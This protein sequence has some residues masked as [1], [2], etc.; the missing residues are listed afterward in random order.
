[1]WDSTGPDPTRQGRIDHTQQGPAA[2]GKVMSTRFNGGR[3]QV[4][5]STT[6]LED[7][8]TEYPV[9]IDPPWS[10]GKLAWTYVDQ[11]YPTT[12]YYNSTADAR[13]GYEA[14]DGTTKRSFFRIDISRVRGTSITAATFALTETWSWSCS[15]RAMQVWATNSISSSTTWNSQPSWAYKTAEKSFAY[16]WYP[17]GQSSPCPNPASGVEFDVKKQVANIAGANGSNVT[18]GLRATNESDTYSW[19]KFK[20]NPT[21]SIQYDTLPSVPS[22]AT[23]IPSTPCSGGYIGNTDVSLSAIP[24]D[25]DGGQVKAQFKFWKST[26]TEPT[27][28]THTVLGTSGTSAKLQLGRPGEGT[29]KWRVRTGSASTSSGD[30]A[31]AYTP[32]C[33]FT[34]DNTAPVADLVTVSSTQFPNYDTTGQAGAPAGVPASFSIRPNDP[35]VTT[36]KVS[37]GATTP[38]V[39]PV[40]SG[41]ATVTLL[42]TLKGP[43]TLNVTVIDGAGN[44]GGTNSDFELFATLPPSRTLAPHDVT[45]DG[46]PDVVRLMTDGRLCLYLGNGAGGFAGGSG[47]TF[48]TPSTFVGTERPVLVGDWND[49][50]TNDVIVLRAN[51]LC[52]YVGNGTGSF[53]NSC[54]D[55]VLDDVTDEI[56]DI[57]ATVPYTDI[58]PAGDFDGDGDPD[59]FG[60]DSAGDLWLVSNERGRILTR[61]GADHTFGSRIG[62]GWGPLL[63]AVPGDVNGDGKPDTFG[64]VTTNGSLNL[65]PGRD[66]TNCVAYP[67]TGQCGFGFGTR[68]TVAT[69]GWSG[70]TQILPAGDWDGNGHPDLMALDA[71]YNLDVYD[72][73]GSNNGPFLTTK[74]LTGTGWSSNWLL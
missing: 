68:S 40:S 58:Y 70:Y 48:I 22:G 50:S 51:K 33:S 17:S 64:R 45:G 25:G 26:S 59:L 61:D 41:L 1:M 72:S 38:I 42:P 35:S 5:P 43:S 62:V 55:I 12:S 19:K 16:N 73:T 44:I 24:T 46:D 27:T 4:T 37:L 8:T 34:I 11:N 10:G 14:Q 39:V 3:L 15:A 66:A 18:I 71:N 23:T 21:L 31:S 7:A 69:T 32:T 13:V 53:G 63:I 2:K 65:Y 29:W 36:I 54:K 56:A 52:L 9:H 28:P 47:C 60:K 20:N 67:D 49:D 6:M 30:P 57:V 74:T